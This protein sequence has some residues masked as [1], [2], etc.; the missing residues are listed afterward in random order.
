MLP[1]S[2]EPHITDN[3]THEI[4]Q[5]LRRSETQKKPIIYDDFVTYFNEIDFDLGNINDSCSYNKAITCAQS[6]QWLEPWMKS[7][8]Q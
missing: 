7:R 2:N 5:P 3:D 1:S 6:T 4:V 8:N